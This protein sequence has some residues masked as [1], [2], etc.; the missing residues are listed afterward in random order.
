MSQ[1][2][3]TTIDR[4][5][6]TVTLNRAEKRNAVDMAMFEAIIETAESLAADPGVRAVVLQGDGGHFC[7]GIDV[8]LFQ[9]AGIGDKLSEL[10]EPRPGSKAN[11][12]QSAAIAWRDLPVPVLAALRGTV[13]GAGL[14]IAMGAD[15]R[16]AAPDV[17]MSIMEVKWG[18][19]PDMGLTATLPGV[20]AADRARELAYTGRIL[21]AAEAHSA[22]LLTEVVD[23][24]LPRAQEIAWNIANKSPDAIRAM[25]R[26][27][28][29]SWNRD[30]ASGLRREAELQ[31][32]V[33][34]GRNQAEAAS[35]N[36]EKRAPRFT[37]S[38]I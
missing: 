8:S 15:M 28:N 5:V 21:S 38:G 32:A 12:F 36:I 29:E 20:V 31:A 18:L 35:A 9:G 4:H 10:L 3:T 27:F 26:L 34:A 6:V 2:I 14:Q 30:P 22:G 13:F 17:R 11:F 37:D 24:P 19:I 33:M 23:D 16:L 25:K 1:R 7:A